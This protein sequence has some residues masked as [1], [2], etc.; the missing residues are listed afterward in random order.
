M[1]NKVF[2]K[3]MNFDFVKERGG[4]FMKKFCFA[5]A[6]VFL[7]VASLV[8]FVPTV[9]FA[10]D[11]YGQGSI[12]NLVPLLPSPYE[13]P[14]GKGDINGDGLVDYLDTIL[15]IDHILGKIKLSNS[16]L[17]QADV[18]L[19]GEADANDL[20]LFP[21]ISPGVVFGDTNNSGTLDSLDLALF[22]SYLLG[23]TKVQPD[24][25]RKYIWDVNVDGNI[26]SLDFA[27]LVQYLLGKRTE[28]PI[29]R[30]YRLLL[31]YS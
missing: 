15:F 6:V 7:I 27:V 22:R 30:Y 14:E 31:A 28:L 10:D 26:D 3:L 1:S 13:I 25:R 24:L 21:K 4:I 23:K 29:E 19:D 17:E 12:N 16:Q 5:S 8:A 9:V 20:A 18:N 11:I 2:N